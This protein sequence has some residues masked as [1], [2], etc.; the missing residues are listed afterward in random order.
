M[1]STGPLVSVWNTLQDTTVNGIIGRE[2]CSTFVFETSLSTKNVGFSRSSEVTSHN[3]PRYGRRFSKTWICLR[4]P[5]K[6]EHIHYRFPSHGG[7][8]IGKIKHHLK[9]NRE[10][11]LVA[12]VIHRWDSHFWVRLERLEVLGR[13]GGL[14]M[15]SVFWMVVVLVIGVVIDSDLYIYN[16]I[17]YS[18]L[19]RFI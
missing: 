7:F 15:P 1:P 17:L 14:G 16:I 8:P 12:P 11:M 5:Q 9:Q 10:N 2:I 19:E 6:I 4:G 3:L 13:V 18:D